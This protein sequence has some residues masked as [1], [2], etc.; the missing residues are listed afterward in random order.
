VRSPRRAAARARRD[1]PLDAPVGPV[2][3]RWSVALVVGFVAVGLLAR[4]V[5]LADGATE[6]W[7]AMPFSAAVQLT[8][9]AVAIVAVERGWRGARAA[10]VLTMAAPAGAVILNAIAVDVWPSSAGHEL[11]ARLGWSP[12]GQPAALHLLLGLALF[13]T[14]GDGRAWGVTRAT[15]LVVALLGAAGA[16]WGHVLGG[17]GVV[18]VPHV[19]PMSAL[20]A[21]A[22]LLAGLGAVA[23]APRRW[24]LS[25]LL[26]SSPGE[27]RL[28]ATLLPFL[29]VVP[30][31]GPAVA[32]LVARAGAA[33]EVTRVVGPT[34]TLAALI[35]F[36]GLVLRAHRALVADVAAHDA[37]LLRVLDELPVAVMLRDQSGR[38][39]HRNEGTERF[40]QRL[41][42]DVAAVAV[43]PN[44][45]IDHVEVV[46]EH[47][48]RPD[49][50]T[51]PVR[52]T[53]RHGRPHS[54]TLGYALPDG[55]RAW[56][57]TRAAPLRLPDGTEGVVVTVD[58]V[59]ER[60]EARHRAAVAERSLRRTFD[61]APIGIA[62][63]TDDGR[64]VQV[65][66]ALCDLVGSDER[67]LLVNGLPWVVEGSVEGRSPWSPSRPGSTAAGHGGPERRLR[68]ADGR[69]LIVEVAAAEVQDDEGPART[70]V[71]VVDVTAQRALQEELRLAAI[72]DPLTGLSNR[73][74][75]A[76]R[77]E[78]ARRRRSRGGGDVGLLYLD[79]DGFK[80][81]NDA[82]GHEVGDRV[83]CDTAERLLA[84]TRDTDT[85]CRLGGDEFVVLCSPID[86]RSGLDQLVERLVAL[87]PVTVEMTGRQVHVSGSI[88][89][90]LLEPGED[91]D[92]VLRRAD[93][94]MY[95]AKRVRTRR[96]S[97]EYAT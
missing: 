38:L 18:F 60:H 30:T 47:G 32:T 13:A 50:E 2:L 95:R 78:A 31:L 6:R 9:L 52:S 72:Q 86:G 24:P 76:E 77:L 20:V 16:L 26:D 74:A 90:V 94:A 33:D 53:L 40:L 97:E 48:R 41:G 44:T 58:D 64:L 11:V 96:T 93:A 4:A 92:D 70:I 17:A 85:V 63:H 65:N 46:D 68:H 34:I 35:W 75:L 69:V 87:P 84:A 39:L 51:L 82:C 3:T 88:G 45:L 27:R 8:L 12:T 7:L 37:G 49:P 73:R 23:V 10:T 71:Q 67:A 19:V 57:S 22:T 42:V 5:G 62:V 15:S 89:A 43:G 91:L 29:L 21:A 25:A 1:V 28:V 66:R 80:A 14:F 59:T 81:V 55:G 54:A 56:Y 36:L 61:E 79:L 83:L